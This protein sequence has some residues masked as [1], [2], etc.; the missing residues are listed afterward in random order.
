MGKAVV[1]KQLQIMG[2]GSFLKVVEQHIKAGASVVMSNKVGEAPHV[3]GKW[4]CC[5]VEYNN[6]DI[7]FIKPEIFDEI[8]EKDMQQVKEG[9]SSVFE[10]IKWV[11]EPDPSITAQWES[12]ELGQSEDHVGV[13]TQAEDVVEEASEEEHKQTKKSVEDVK[14]ELEG[15][16]KAEIIKKVKT[17]TGEI[18]VRSNKNLETIKQEAVDIYLKQ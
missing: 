9:V 1:K 5:Y 16:T 12:G 8:A 17:D 3:K 4:Y 10:E 7:T 15:L 13:S 14:A 6:E 2:L 11:G 18:I